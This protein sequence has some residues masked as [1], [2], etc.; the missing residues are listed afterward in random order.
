MADPRIRL[1]PVRGQP[2]DP[3]A[4]R[5]RKRARRA[6]RGRGSG[7][8][9]EM[10]GGAA[11]R[12][13]GARGGGRPGG[14]RGVGDGSA[15][16]VA[17]AGGGGRSAGG[18]GAGDG[19]LGALG[20]GAV[21]GV[22][23][24]AGGRGGGA[25]GRGGGQHPAHLLGRDGGP[26]LSDSGSGAVSQRLRAGCAHGWKDPSTWGRTR[27]PPGSTQPFGTAARLRLRG[28][29]IGGR[30]LRGGRE[31]GRLPLAIISGDLSPHHSPHVACP[32]R[33]SDPS[34]PSD[35]GIPLIPLSSPAQPPPPPPPSPPLLPL[36]PPAP[37]SAG[38]AAR[39]EVWGA[40]G[41]VGSRQDI[42]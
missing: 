6:G 5:D 42:K 9:R 26:H 3:G 41:R 38:Q 2:R 4:P 24:A 7:A 37:P 18:R 29:G 11:G 21:L 31:R 12:A 30:A 19:G 40:N 39:K 33:V 27:S 34:H 17:A 22:A 28:D 14:G 1:G 35:D 20:G 25:G 10:A 36:P 13:A 8:A 32:I 23:S 15:I 16:G